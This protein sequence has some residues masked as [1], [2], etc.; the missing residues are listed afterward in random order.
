MNN[1]TLS[2][3]V[4]YDKFMQTYYNIIVINTMPTGPLSRMVRRLPT[5]NMRPYNIQMDAWNYPARRPC[6]LALASL[7]PRSYYSYMSVE[8]VPDLFS[9]LLANGYKIDTHITTIMTN[10]NIRYTDGN[11]IAFVTYRPK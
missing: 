2:S 11:I 4:Y 9:Y 10:Q 6:L 8:E 7:H 3:Q 5:P 1:F